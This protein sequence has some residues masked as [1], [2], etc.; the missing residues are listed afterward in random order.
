[1]VLILISVAM[2]LTLEALRRRNARLR[3]LQD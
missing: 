1:V 2:L 3:G